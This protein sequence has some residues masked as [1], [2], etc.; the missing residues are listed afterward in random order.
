[1]AA[2]PTTSAAASMAGITAHAPTP[3][4]GPAAPVSGKAT[5]A[6][7]PRPA[8]LAPVSPAP[9]PTRSATRANRPIAGILAPVSGMPRWLED[10]LLGAGLLTAAAYATEPV[11][12]LARRR[13]QRGDRPTKRGE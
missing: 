12:V 6:P 13:R 2:V 3:A 4:A 11:A 8:E 10:V 5:K 7:A 1:L 9:T